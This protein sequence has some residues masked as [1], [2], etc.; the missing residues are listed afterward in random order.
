[1]FLRIKGL[2]DYSKSQYLDLAAL[3][4]EDEYGGPTSRKMSPEER[5]NRLMA[6]NLSFRILQE[7]REKKFRR[8]TERSETPLQ[9]LRISRGDSRHFGFTKSPTYGLI[10]KQGSP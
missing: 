3:R 9:H 5:T 10:E 6:H 1:M 8:S 2:S 7:S 4:I